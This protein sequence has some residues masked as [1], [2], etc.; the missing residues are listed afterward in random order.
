MN[1]IAIYIL[2]KY[3]YKL[4]A[5]ELDIVIQWY[6]ENK[7]SIK[8]EVDLDLEIRAFLY[9]QSELYVHV[10]NAKKV[11]EDA[12]AELTVICSNENSE[13][14]DVQEKFL[15]AYNRYTDFFNEV[16]DFCIMVNIGA[17]KA[18]DYIKNTIAVNISKY[19][20][21]QY[22]TFSV[23]QEIAKEYN[24]K[25]LEKPDYKAFEDYDKFL[26]SYNGGDSSAFWTDIKTKHRQAGFE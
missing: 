20:K 15:R 11:Y 10:K 19:A 23:L 1:D 8:N 26:I 2:K 25:M 6:E 3:G 7:D 4:T 5:D 14:K 24:F 22:E 17:I 9:K 12:M 21:I 13:K 18:E 16:N